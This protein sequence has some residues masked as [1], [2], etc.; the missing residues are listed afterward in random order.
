[1]VRRAYA[2]LVCIVMLTTSS[3]GLA[4]HVSSRPSVWDQR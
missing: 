3:Y 1:M 4:A 2:V